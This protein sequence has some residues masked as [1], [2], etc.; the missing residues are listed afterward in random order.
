M[1]YRR[2]LI[3]NVISQ[4][5]SDSWDIAKREWIIADYNEDKECNGVCI[6]GKHRLKNLYQITNT[7]NC[8]FINNI[9]SECMKHFEFNEPDSYKAKIL[10]MK[11]KILKAPGTKY[12]GQEYGEIVKN[13]SYMDFLRKNSKKKCFEKLIEYYDM[14]E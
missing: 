1:E 5:E 12:D 9:G 14:C 2:T 11:H 13:T 7:R 10:A 4:S 3:N 8:N 6:C